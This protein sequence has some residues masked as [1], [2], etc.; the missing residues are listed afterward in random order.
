MTLAYVLYIILCILLILLILLQP[1]KGGGMGAIGGGAGGNTVFGATGAAGFLSKVTAWMGAIFMVASFA[2]A[3]VKIQS[4]IHLKAPAA[5]AESGLTAGTKDKGDKKD[6]A[7]AQ[8]DECNVMRTYNAMECVNGKG[9]WDKTPSAFVA[10][11]LSAEVER[12]NKL[13]RA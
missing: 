4:G 2:L 9:L 13:R 12:K 11:W 1:G 7:K 6:D 8:K 3:A 10:V 5:P